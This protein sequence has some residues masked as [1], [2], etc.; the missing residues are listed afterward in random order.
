ME[1]SSHVNRLLSKKFVQDLINTNKFKELYTQLSDEV[2]D[3]SYIGELTELLLAADI[4]PLNNLDYIPEN[5]LTDSNIDNISIPNNIRII[6][7]MSFAYCNN[8]KSIIFPTS[9]ET[10]EDGAFYSCKSLNNVV[11]PGNV[12]IIEQDAFR[13]CDSLKNV[14]IEKGVQ[15]I[16]RHAFD[17]CPLLQSITYTGTIE[18]LKKININFYGISNSINI[19]CIDGE[20]GI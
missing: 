6:R 1:I 5:Y 11:I 7:F 17:N 16:G 14:T 9:L 19:K 3:V 20:I 13:F 4:N 2:P 12:K 18:D 10:I 15:E 8:L